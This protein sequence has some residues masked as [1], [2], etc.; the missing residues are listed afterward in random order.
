MSAGRSDRD[1]SVTF[2]AATMPCNRASAAAGIIVMLVML[3]LPLSTS[4]AKLNVPRVLL[5]YSEEGV[6]FVLESDEPGGC[7][8]WRSTRPEVGDRETFTS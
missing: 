7:F 2:G 4:G 8:K 3:S 1:V 6:D 5:P